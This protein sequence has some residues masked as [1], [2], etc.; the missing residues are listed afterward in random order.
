MPIY[1]QLAEDTFQRADENPLTAS[2]WTLTTGGVSAPIQLKN[3]QAIGTLV[4][5]NTNSMYYSGATLG[6]NQY[7]EITVGALAPGGVLEFE[8]RAT[9]D[10]TVGYIVQAQSSALVFVG[11]AIS[12]VLSPFSVLPN[13]KIRIECLGTKISLFYNGTLMLSQVDAAIASGIVDISLFPATVLTDTSFSKFIAG[14]LSGSINPPTP[15]T[16]YGVFNG[17]NLASAFTNPF[18]MDLMQVVNAGNQV[19]WNLTSSGITNVNPT[20]PTPNALICQFEGSSFA[21]AFPNLNKLDL[22]QIQAPGGSVPFHVD[23]QGN[24]N[25]V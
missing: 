15:G 12:L 8:A 6:A 10:S 4:V 13:D 23:Y 1:T 7:V 11:G 20:S 18:R 16:V 17:R 19:V 22:M 24:A 2:K 21:T 3:H 5:G 9:L 14:N 25:Y